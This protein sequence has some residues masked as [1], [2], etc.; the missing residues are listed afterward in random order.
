MDVYR[1]CWI[2]ELIVLDVQ[3]IDTSPNVVSCV[4]RGN[5]YFIWIQAIFF[6]RLS[7]LQFNFSFIVNSWFKSPQYPYTYLWVKSNMDLY[8]SYV[9]IGMRSTYLPLHLINSSD[10]Y[11]M[12]NAAKPSHTI[13]IWYE[14][15]GRI[16]ESNKVVTPNW[17]A[18][19]LW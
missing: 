18:I 3:W 9:V 2:R 13:N 5:W 4:S 15:I 16:I 10:L 6:A 12:F 14:L 17:P 8:N 11:S 1:D 7:I 19:L